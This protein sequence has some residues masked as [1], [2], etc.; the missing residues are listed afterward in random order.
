MGLTQAIRLS[1]K[2]VLHPSI[3]MGVRARNATNPPC[4]DESLDFVRT[5][6]SHCL[7][8]GTQ[9]LKVCALSE[10]TFDEPMAAYFLETP[11]RQLPV[12][13]ANKT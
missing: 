8:S 4:S 10:R 11:C 2:W 1:S 6:F 13:S 5:G 9:L 3:L 7:A 12:H